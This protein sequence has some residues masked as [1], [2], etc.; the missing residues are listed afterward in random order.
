MNKSTGKTQTAQDAG[1]PPFPCKPSSLWI[2]LQHSPG[3]EARQSRSLDGE[4]Q[5]EIIW[6]E[7]KGTLPALRFVWFPS[8]PAGINTDDSDPPE[9][10]E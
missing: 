8:L 10:P 7:E 6:R 3:S 2:G 9:S 1:R 5:S 4:D